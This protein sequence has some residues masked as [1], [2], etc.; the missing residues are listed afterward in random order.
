MRFWLC[1]LVDEVGILDV[2]VVDYFLQIGL[3]LFLEHTVEF[4]L[5]LDHLPDGLAH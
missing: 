1:V 4:L 2:G 3:S 5:V